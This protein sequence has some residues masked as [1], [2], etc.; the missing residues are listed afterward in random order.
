MI[1]KHANQVRDL[2][3]WLELHRVTLDW[4]EYYRRF[5]QAHGEPILF[6]GRLLFRDG[7]RYSCTSYGG[8]EIE[9]PPIKA[10]L[11]RLQRV[12]WTERRKFVQTEINLI[13][14]RM[15]RLKQEQNMRSMPLVV[16]QRRFEDGKLRVE[17]AEFGPDYF[18]GRLAWLRGD[19]KDC[20]RALLQLDKE[21]SNGRP[22]RR[23]LP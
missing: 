18:S 14:A 4:R 16:K 9:P 3:D 13:E 8:E 20:E 10:D 11:L 22:S 19:L 6:E 5:E 7:W 1:L 21:S 2:Y 17:A 12:Y 23:S 15:Q